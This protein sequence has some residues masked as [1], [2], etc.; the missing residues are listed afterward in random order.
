MA[1]EMIAFLENENE[2]E[3]ISDVVF[4]GFDKDC[5]GYI[6]VSELGN[7][8]KELT[9]DVKGAVQP[10]HEQ[11]KLTMKKMDKD[12]NGSLNLSEFKTFM[13]CIVRSIAHTLHEN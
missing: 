11:I 4:Q 9:K 6:S 2:F 5:S 7:A 8:M 3:K 10:T 12:G 13:K 1:E